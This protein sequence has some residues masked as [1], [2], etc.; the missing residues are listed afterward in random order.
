MDTRSIFR[1]AA[2]L[3]GSAGILAALLI[4]FAGCGSSGLNSPL[5]AAGFSLQLDPASRLAADAGLRLSEPRM[6]SDALL[7]LDVYCR[8]GAELGS[9]FLSL[10]FD[11][12]RYT[13]VAAE[14]CELLSAP[15]RGL[16]LALL[17]QPGSVQL[18]QCLLGAQ[19]SVTAGSPP[20]ASFSFRPEPSPSRRLTSAVPD[21][22]AERMPLS[23][24]AAS[25]ELSWEYRCQG[26][27]NMDGRVAISDLAPIGLYFG[28]SG[29]FDPSSAI[30]Q[31][32]G[33][34]DGQ[35]SVSDL[36][37]I[38]LNFGTQV[39]S[40][41]VY[42]SPSSADYPLG[43]LD[44]NGSGAQ[45]KASV[46]F[47]AAVMTAGQR[48][49]WS[50]SVDNA[51]W[52]WWVR[53]SDGNSEGIAS[54]IASDS[55]VNLAPL[56]Q[57]NA[58]PSSGA[59]PLQ[60]SLTAQ[61]SDPDGNITEYRFDAEGD[62]V[63]E[64]VSASQ[65]SISHT[66]SVA[67]N[68]LAAVQVEDEDGAVGSASVMISVSTDGNSAPLLDVELSRDAG[69]APFYVEFDLSGSSDSDGISTYLVD[70][71]SDGVY[72]LDS[73][74][75]LLRATLNSP[76]TANLLFTVTDNLGASSSQTVSVQ[77]L[78]HEWQVDIVAS[79]PA[80]QMFQTG[81]AGLS[82][83]PGQPWR[84]SICTAY[85]TASENLLNYYRAPQQ[86]SD[87]WSSQGVSS[88]FNGSLL[89]SDLLNYNGLPHLAACVRTGDGAPYQLWFRQSD[90]S[91]GSDWNFPAIFGPNAA[92]TVI[93]TA[94]WLSQP[95]V[96]SRNGSGGLSFSR[97]ENGNWLT[98]TDLVESDNVLFYAM[99]SNGDDVY[100]VYSESAAPGLYS[101][102]CVELVQD[103]VQVAAGPPQLIAE[104]LSGSAQPDCVLVDDRLL[105]SFIDGQHVYSSQ[106]DVSAMNLWSPPIEAGLCGSESSSYPVVT[107]LE[108][109]SG[110][111]VCA[112]NGNGVFLSHAVDPYAEAWTTAEAIDS[113]SG[114]GHG[115]D[116]CVISGQPC[117]S[118]WRYQSGSLMCAA[119]KEVPAN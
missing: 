71:N 5:D 24:D 45:L 55:A 94:I 103:G 31:V 16:E 57:L 104:D 37:A 102:Y 66:Y 87:P 65:N 19:A 47:S 51:A 62:G 27:Y 118:Y 97:R 39:R 68:Y 95:A 11:A 119:R 60:I 113:L 30:A 20:L 105:V 29:P 91:S 12:T 32:D 6:S 80:T 18:G 52:Y 117:L 64:T 23:L 40:F 79:T 21:S 82:D 46:D 100:V 43:S 63:F 34:G 110:V 81:I 59:A 115:L 75:P 41:E 72:D 89:G 4:S 56:V 106:C 86:D 42:S 2:G 85:K 3:L 50:S 1:R 92:S 33:N 25:G 67:G 53:P 36:S 69:T 99:C 112:W 98:T 14:G 77:V 35:I 15:G 10:D 114:A 101:L 116:M 93:D 44:A 13:P 61:A 7:Q 83:S 76:G 58:S 17:D 88:N 107:R 48:L 109:A 78:E 22:L 90:S 84:P 73:T 49:S 8:P 108:L 111:P 70:L 96:L 9:L 28:S 38:G 26:D 54:Q 74:Q